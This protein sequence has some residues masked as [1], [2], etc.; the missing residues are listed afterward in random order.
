[1]H[2]TPHW[3]RPHPGWNLLAEFRCEPGERLEDT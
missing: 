3:L 2:W 1:M